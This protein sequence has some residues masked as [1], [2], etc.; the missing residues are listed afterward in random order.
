MSRPF[1]SSPQFTGHNTPS[2]IECDLADLVVEGT[3]PDDIQ[4]SW[5]RSIPDPQYPP[6]LG[7]DVYLSGDGMVSLFRFENG[8]VSL[9][10]R[11]VRTERWK[12]ERAAG[13]SLSGRYRN[14]FTD[15]PSVRGKGRGVANTTPLYHAGRLIAL[16]E[17]S[18]GWE[19]DPQTLETRGEWNYGGKLRS[20]TMTP[21]PRIDPD[22]GELFFFGYE[23][24][25]LATRDVAYCIADAAGELR[26]EQW[27]EA[28]FCALMHDFVVTKEHAIFP[29]FPLTADLERLRQ[30]GPHWVW[31]PELGTQIGIMPR[32]GS[33]SEMRWFS[34]PACSG[35]HHVDGFTQG[36]LVHVD[37]SLTNV[38]VFPFMR[39]D[40]GLQIPQY[41]VQGG[42]ERWTF[43]LSDPADRITR[44]LLG[45]AGDLPRLADEFAMSDYDILYYERYEPTAGPPITT[46]AVGPGFNALTRL[47]VNTGRMTTLPMHPRTTL[48][49]A[50]H[51]RSKRPGHEGY[52]AFVVDL[53]DENLSDVFVVEAADVTRGPIAKIKVPFRL[54]SGVHGTW[55]PRN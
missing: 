42:L 45:P 9:R 26:S 43:D 36:D 14:P 51:I 49:E 37:M 29:C 11:Y 1:P 5:Y 32:A 46:G 30:G 15:D 54:R 25:G 44:R 19:L 50:I 38:P 17:D 16:K 53:H 22:T 20:Q 34:A 4:G 12:N 8:R 6:M 55:V 47:D 18:L 3:L 7:D 52:L 39:E 13:R 33:V 2:R 31:Q 35:F 10:M 24:G 23:A 48:Q 28:P 40:S 41:E 21:H 27:F